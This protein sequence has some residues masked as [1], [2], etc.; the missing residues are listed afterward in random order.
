MSVI[1]SAQP[2]RLEP[3]LIPLPWSPLSISPS[4][5][6][7]LRIAVMYS[8]GVVLPHSPLIRALK[9][10]ASEL[11]ALPHVKS[12]E[13]K[14]HLHD[15][16]WA[17]ISSLYFPDAG[18][19]DI[20]IMEESGEPMLPLTRWIIKENPCVKNL[21]MGE[22]WYWLEEKEAYKSEYAKV[23]EEFDCGDGQKPDVIICPVGPGVAPKHNTAE[24]WGYTSVWN[25]LD[26]PALVVPLDKV[27][28]KVDVKGKR[29]RY[30]N[31]IDK[32]NWELYDPEEFHG[33][34]ISLQIVGRRF[35][36][37]KCIAVAEFLEKQGLIG[38]W[39]G[40]KKGV[41]IS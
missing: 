21:S 14:P 36:D 33:L 7:P 9:S 5:S 32:E 41:N 8:D 39:E 23:W 20:A 11:A 22:L 18:A 27:D 17:I 6:Q 16:S 1:L 31:D 29:R 24:Y 37:E 25:L 38:D 40:K 4:A 12:R 35:E 15:E 10:L 34:P 26:Y 19:S 3:A 2:W 30:M 13:F 28:K